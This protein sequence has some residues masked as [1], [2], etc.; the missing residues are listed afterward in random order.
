M[1]NISSAGAV[2]LYP[3]PVS[4]TLNLDWGKQVVHMKMD[5]YNIVGQAVLH[6]EI[7]GQSHHETDLS[8]LPPGAYMVVLQDSDGNKA[9]FKID[10]TQ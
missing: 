9:T 8:R 1:K 7:D 3:N 6:E 5:L 2:N 10:H 4:G